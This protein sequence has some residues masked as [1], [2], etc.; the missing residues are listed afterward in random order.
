MVQAPRRTGFSGPTLVR[1]LARLTDVDVPESGQSLSDRLSLWL[2]WTDAIAL[3]AVLDGKPP[4]MAP[5]GPTFDSEQDRE[6]LKLRTTLADAIASD[7]EFTAARPRGRQPPSRTQA[8]PKAPTD[9]DYSSFRQRYLS[10]QHTMENGI[11]GLRSRLRGM[12][13]GRN[14]EMTRLAMVDAIME[15]SLSV[16]ERALM[17]T[18]PTLLGAH[19][20]RLRKAEQS[21]Q[22]EAEAAEMPP[23][24]KP[25]AWLDT[26]RKD[27][28]SV[29]LAELDIRFQPVEGLL[30][31]LRTR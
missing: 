26:F 20:E 24:A 3:A 13:A 25:G 6:S 14:P 21:A 18:I 19:F 31:A 12:L 29:L 4:A 17:T 27:M 22:E 8:V 30:A 28:R 1:L 9:A 5:G 15:R 2:G 11:G 23:P 10:L 16:R 7:T